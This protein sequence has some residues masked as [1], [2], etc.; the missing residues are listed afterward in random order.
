MDEYEIIYLDA[1]ERNATSDHRRPSS[2]F[3]PIRRR[4]RVMVPTHRPTVIRY[5]GSGRTYG[6]RPSTQVMVQQPIAKGGIAGLSIGEL[7]ELAAGILA[8]IQ[9]LPGA[10]TAQGKVETDVENLVVYQAALANHAKHD[11]RL[12][13][14]GSLLGRL[15]K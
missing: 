9:P 4:P 7:I 1:E 2:G 3:P 5:G 8:A 13:T 14:L 12:R 11:E 6:E 15:L 10:P